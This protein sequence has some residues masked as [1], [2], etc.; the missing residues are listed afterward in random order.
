[1]DT[2]ETIIKKYINLKDLKSDGAFKVRQVRDLQIT[3]LTDEF[4]LV[5]ACDS[6]G[7]IGPKEL[8]SFYSPAYDLGRFG[9]RVPIMEILASGAHPFSVID[10]LAVEMD[11]TGKEVIKGVK[12]EAAYAGIT[13][14]KSITGSTEDNVKTLQTGIGVVVL[15]FVEKKDFR[16]GRSL[17]GDIV[18]CIG[19][20]KSAPEFKLHY[21]DPDIADPKLIR[22]LSNIE[23]VHDILPVGSKGIA[24]EFLQM[25]KS[26]G[27]EG[28]YTDSLS[29]DIH[30]SGGPSACCLV[31][32]PA[33]YFNELKDLTNKPVLLVGE[34]RKQDL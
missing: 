30:K 34:L 26:A 7:G 18:L 15:G 13:C 14:D 10:V 17:D 11:P 25:A 19:Y 28:Y 20:P 22:L 21:S 16:P 23:F 6:D 32:L 24:H 5:I 33:S 2:Q 29:V 8:D 1:M 12:D 3:E 31:S 9:A 4:W 27:L